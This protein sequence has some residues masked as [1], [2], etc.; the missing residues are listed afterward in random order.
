V[1]VITSFLDSLPF[2]ACFSAAP[3]SRSVLG[4]KWLRSPTGS[5]IAIRISAAI[6]TTVMY[7][8]RQPTMKSRAPPVWRRDIC[9]IRYRSG[10]RER[11]GEAINVLV[12]M[13]SS[14]TF[15]KWPA[16]T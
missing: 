9:Q 5:V 14:L 13:A 12:Y 15:C 11:K 7:Q 10:S 1:F 16:V 4:Q 3:I 6:M 2:Q 8:P